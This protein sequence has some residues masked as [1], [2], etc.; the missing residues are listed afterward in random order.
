M[1]SIGVGAVIRSDQGDFVQACTRRFDSLLQPREAEAISLREALS[2]VKELGFKNCVFET[3][4]KQLDDACN[5]VHGE[6]Y[7][8]TI[9]LDCVDYCKHFENVLVKF[10]H[11]SVNVVAHK[12]ARATS[13]MSD[14]QEWI[15]NPPDFVHESLVYD[16][17]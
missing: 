13:S 5:G 16:S 11:R 8:H 2:L 10:V 4:A 14:L 15:T 17:I 7:F 1:N 6:S 3:D 12:L 9:V